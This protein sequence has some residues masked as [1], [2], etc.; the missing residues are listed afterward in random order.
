MLPDNRRRT[1]PE[2]VALVHE[3][4]AAMPAIEQTT[5][6]RYYRG[7]ESAASIEAALNLPKGWIIEI[8]RELRRQFFLGLVSR[9]K[10]DLNRMN[11]RGAEVMDREVQ[12]V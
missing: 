6:A 1:S 12:E 2:D 4:L 3:L 10:I 11:R 7:I 9:D 8:H 5:L